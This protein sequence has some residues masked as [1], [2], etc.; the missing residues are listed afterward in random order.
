MEADT[1]RGTLRVLMQDSLLHI[2]WL[3][4]PGGQLETANDIIVFPNDAV[5]ERVPEC[6]TG[7][8]YLLRLKQSNKKR[9]FWMQEPSDAKDEEWA[10]QINQHINNPPQDGGI[11][12]PAGLGGLGALGLG[13]LAGLGGQGGPDLGE[14]SADMLND[15]SDEDA[16]LMELISRPAGAPAPAAAG[17]GANRQAAAGAGSGAR[18]PAANLADLGLNDLSEEDAQLMDLITS[19]AGAQAPA[20][21]AAQAPAPAPAPA[22]SGSS[23]A[24]QVNINALASAFRQFAAHLQAQQQLEG[25]SLRSVL[26]ADRVIPILDTDMKAIESLL[27]YLPEGQRDIE[28]MRDTIRSPQM[29]QTLARMTQVLNS[30]QC[31]ALFASLGLPQGDMGVLGFIKAIQD[32]V[33]KESKQQ[34]SQASASS[35]PPSQS[36]S[37]SAAAAQPSQTQSQSQAPSSQSS[38][39]PPK[40]PA[41][42]S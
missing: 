26:E 13:G 3:T 23:A 17:S 4:R 11:G 42:K 22:P 32:Q 24:P 40:D 1:R 25:L 18:R 16:Q 7:R 2:Q 19:S 34:P 41:K 15:M 8:V 36:Q 28:N 9:F 30:P 6:K 29:Y 39:Q 38:Q 10:K 21:G 35:N 31:G 37:Q 5:W 12:M 20:A 27:P 14:L 33:D